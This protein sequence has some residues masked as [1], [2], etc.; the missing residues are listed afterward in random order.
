[1]SKE[2]LLARFNC[3][4]VKFS[5][6]ADALYD[7]HLTFDHVTPAEKVTPR[8]KF[9]AVTRSVRD[10]LSQRWLKTE[11]TYQ[12]RNAK[13]VYYLSLEFLMGRA[14]ANNIT[15]LMLGPVWAQFCKERKI[16]PLELLAQE[17]DPGLGNGGCFY[18]PRWHYDNEPE[19]RAALNLIASNHFSLHEPGV[20]EPIL[21]TLLARGDHYLHLAD[22]KS[23]SGA[24]ARL[25]ELYQDQEGWARKA[26][27][28]IAASGK[29]S[30]DRT[31]AEYAKEIW[32]V[33]SCFV[34]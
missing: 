11:Q 24:H 27:L 32:Q 18:S 8:D 20:F 30:S 23:Y 19:T 29:F 15:N 28:N 7:R 31:I 25:G 10:L 17:P 3:G 6:G 14:L 22:L 16:D 21:D 34:E 12:E 13:R 33:K 2:N 1:M 26:T 5:G 9:E 4:P